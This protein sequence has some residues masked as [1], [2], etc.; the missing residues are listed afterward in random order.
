[1]TTLFHEEG[2]KTIQP[3]SC[4]T[5]GADPSNRIHPARPQNTFLGFIWLMHWLL[6]WRLL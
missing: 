3:I 6:C 2:L 1:M 4:L 5:S